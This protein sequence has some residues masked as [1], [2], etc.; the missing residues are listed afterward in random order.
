M[1]IPE[2]NLIPQLSRPTR[3]LVTGAGGAAA[4]SVLRALASQ[5]VLLYAGDVDLHAVGLYLFPEH[6]RVLLPRGD[7]PAFVE[8]VSSYCEA[9]EVDV[10]IPTVDSELIP[11]AERADDLRALGTEMVLADLATL[12]V[13][14]DK[15]DLARACVG[16]VPV[17]RSAALDGSFRPAGWTF[18]VIVKPRTGSGGRG[19]RMVRSPEE[20]EGLERDGTLMV[21]EYLPGEEYSV[22][23]FAD[24]DG[25]VRAC[26]PRARLKVDSGVAVAARTLR[27]AE[28][29]GLAR[30]VAQRIGL[31]Y[32]ANVQFRRDREG[33]PSLLEVNPRFPGT[34]PLTVR[35]GVNMPLLAVA[36]ATGAEPPTGDL[37]FEEVAVVRHWEEVFIAAA[38]LKAKEPASVDERAAT[39]CVAAA[40]A[41]GT[42]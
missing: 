37:E 10:L 13:C 12:R 14:L 17:P 20:L 31:R 18:P 30:A 7:D 2:L 9:E 24:Q 34:M 38:D 22:D 3:V 33:W 41:F 19:V 42:D 16:I 29:E 25:R 40:A 26:V 39:A 11:L 32:V 23:V 15:L 28:L 36:A 1:L 6:R 8:R 35:A 4:V 27:D 21:Q 5:D